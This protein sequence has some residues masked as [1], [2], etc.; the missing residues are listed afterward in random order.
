MDWTAVQEAWDDL[1]DR[2]QTQ[3]PATRALDIALV[4]GDRDR[5]TAHLA[6]AH[7]LTAAEA[8]EAIDLWLIR[9]GTLRH[10]A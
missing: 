1:G 4:A 5:F 9:L 7:D 6:E 8:A 10:A 3:W 2:I